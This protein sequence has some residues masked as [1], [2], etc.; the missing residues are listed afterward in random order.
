MEKKNKIR[1]FFWLFIF[2][3]FFTLSLISRK[4]YYDGYGKYGKIRQELSKI[5]EIFDSLE[6][7][8][9]SK[10]NIKSK[11]QKNQIIIHYKKDDINIKYT[12][13]YEEIANMKL[14]KLNY[15][16]LNIP[17]SEFIAKNMIDAISI[18]N[19]NKE[20][21]LFRF[22]N[23]S[24]FYKTTSKN[25]VNLSQKD[26]QFYLIININTNLFENLENSDLKKQNNVFYINKDDLKEL[27]ANL[28]YNNYFVYYK[29][30]NI[31][32]IYKK[33]TSYEIYASNN[34]ENMK[35]LYLSIM[36]ATNILNHKIY[37]EIITSN[38]RYDEDIETDT[39][40]FEINPKIDKNKIKAN[41][42]YII[43]LTIK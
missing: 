26:G 7:I 36:S 40:K 1:L 27:E 16:N 39:Y 32:E 13:V 11:I 43:K 9:E 34:T 31:I 21:K 22:Y 25:G 15:D 37:D 17:V 19:G 14:L 28:N 38:Y 41:G 3:I 10:A 12:F 4:L 5:T 35:Y 33:N 30:D 20:K 6:N 42:K 2:I 18:L 23:Y 8:K 24:D 29:G